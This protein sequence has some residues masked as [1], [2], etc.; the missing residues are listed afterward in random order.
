MSPKSRA[1]LTPIALSGLLITISTAAAQERMADDE[2][3]RHLTTVRSQIENTSLNLSRR[4]ELALEMAGTLDRAAQSSTDPETRRRHWSEAIDLLDW[5]LKQHPDL[6]RERQLRFQAGLYRW[7]QARSWTDTAVFDLNDPRPREQGAQALDN[8]IERFRA[9]AGDGNSPTL[10]DNLRF[11]LAEALADRADLYPAASSDRRTRER[12]ALDLLNQPPTEVGLAGYWHLLKAD[13][14][15]RSAKPAEAEKEIAAAVKSTPPPPPRE[16]VEVN[17]PLLLEQRKIADA[18]KALDSSKIDKATVALWMAR[19]RLTERIGLPAGAERFKV[20]TDLFHWVNELRGGNTPERR[21]V[22]LDLARAEVQ[23]DARQPAE[24]WDALADAYGTAGEPAKAGAEMAKAAEHAAEL[25]QTAAAMA[26]RLRGGGFLLRAARFIEADALLSKVADDPSAG[27]LRAKAG[28]LRCLARGQA[29][30]LGLQ[31]S[32]SA[33]YKAAL[34]Q[35]LR[36]FPTDPSTDEA[37]WLLGQLAVAAGD[38]ARAETLWSAIAAVSPRWLDSRL[39]IAALDRDE[40]DRTLINPDRHQMQIIYQQADHFLDETIRRT[41]SEG[42]LAE[43]LLARARLELTPIVGRPESARELCERVARLAVGPGLR[44]RARLYRLVA[45]VETSRYVEAER[46]AQTHSSWQVRTEHDAF[47]DSVRLLDHG[48]AFAESDLRQRRFG[49]V[50]RLILEPL[51]A[52]DEKTDT[53]GRSELAMRY[54]RALLAVGADREARRSLPAWRGGPQ[55]TD[56]RVLRDLGDTYHRLGAHSLNID[57]QRLRLKN[58]PSGSLTWLDARYALALA[59]FNTG[60]A[61]DAA[62]LIDSTA[63]LHPDLGGNALHDKFVH[64]RQRLGLKP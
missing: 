50:L 18:I 11:R 15:R 52:G 45:L 7:A 16:V 3:S 6:P 29:L 4:E 20:D 5:F 56:E 39:A 51:V 46:E 32:S 43:L 34:E 44:Y 2:L 55:S 17:V 40:L 1:R 49:L 30:E 35:Q 57:V 21:Q 26:Y 28:M 37:R 64:L 31:G 24:V 58:N 59:Y 61:K 19:I 10:A 12:E 53:D 23:P 38:R 54:T 13:L 62:Q 25:G 9:V 14:L 27:S 63:I 41:R 42:A 60:R 22:L 33:S 47:F 8:A 36:D 48:A